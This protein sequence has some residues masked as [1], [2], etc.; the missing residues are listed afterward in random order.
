ME[1]W[2]RLHPGVNQMEEV[3]DL[4]RIR[5]VHKGFGYNFFMAPRKSTGMSWLYMVSG[6]ALTFIMVYVP[7]D[8]N[9][10]Q[11]NAW[12]KFGKALYNTFARGLFSVGLSI[13][14]APL[15]AGRF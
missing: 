14:L 10:V 13:V 3:E 11:G 15:L 5:K 8:V 2:H 9:R 6:F 1:E 12:Q 7:F 4:R